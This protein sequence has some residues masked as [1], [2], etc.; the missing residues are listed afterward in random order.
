VRRGVVVSVRRTSGAASGAERDLASSAA[1]R[2]QEWGARGGG[3]VT[4]T[5]NASVQCVALSQDRSCRRYFH[6]VKTSW[7][8]RQ[9]DTHWVRI[10]ERARDAQKKRAR[11]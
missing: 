9:Q 6:V 5:W 2:G 8:S 10:G 1:A 7:F 3:V 11:G 4:V